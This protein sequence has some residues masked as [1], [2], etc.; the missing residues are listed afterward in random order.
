[1]SR[2]RWGVLSTA[3]IGMSKVTSAIQAASNSEVVQGLVEMA[4][5]TFGRLDALVA[6]AGIGAYGGILD[7]T[8]DQLAD[9]MDRSLQEPLADSSSGTWLPPLRQ[10]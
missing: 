9:M 8:D 5:A 6:N 4:Y 10:R 1:M 2:V 3:D 7:L